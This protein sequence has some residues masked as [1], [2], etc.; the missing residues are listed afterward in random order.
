MIVEG[1]GRIVAG[2]RDPAVAARGTVASFANSDPSAPTESPTRSLFGAPP[3][4]ALRP[5]RVSRAGQAPRA[6]GML[7]G[8]LAL[9]AAG[10]PDPHI[11][12]EASWRQPGEAI[13]ALLERP[14][15]GKVVLHVD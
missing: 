7:D 14:V 10:R 11:D 4:R 9:V 6:T 1:V 13:K 3:A 8:L 2:C 12:L 15:A 5:A